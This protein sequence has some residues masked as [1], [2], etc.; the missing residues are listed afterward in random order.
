MTALQNETATPTANDKIKCLVD[1]QMVHSI[2]NHIE[3]NL[4][5]WTIQ[6][7]QEAYPDTPLFS[8]YGEMIKQ[9]ALKNAE[10][11]RKQREEK[12]RQVADAA[13]APVAGTSNNVVVGNFGGKQAE[14]ISKV[15]AMHELFDLGAVPA[16]MG[17]KGQPIAVHYYEGHTDLNSLYL[18][19]TDAA[20]VFNIDLLK[21]VILALQLNFPMLLWGKHGTGK[22][23]IVAQAS[24]RT[25]RPVMRVQ[26]TMNM[27]ESDVIGQWTV[28]NSETVFE[29]GPL[30]TA[31]LNGWVYIADEYDFAMPAVTALYQ[32]VLEGEALII[33]DA[34]AHLRKIVPHENFR[35]FATGNTNGTG[36][37]TGLYQGTT[38]Q[39]AANYSRF[40]ITE[41]VEYM[42]A[43]I[44]EAIISAKT[45]VDK[46]VS[47]NL[48]KFANQVRS[49]FTEGKISS[50]IS[51]RELISAAQIGF[52][53]GGK[54]A[55]GLQ[56]AF[57]NRLS[58]VDK[59]ACEQFMN[60][61]FKDG[62]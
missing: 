17:S 49:S 50:T 57:S 31:M 2:Q 14:L 54:W 16:A 30:P 20:Y 22:T 39:N 15:G 62:E 21:K 9:R 13:P 11:Q 53:F 19:A 36:D 25:G 5:E 45:G 24:A 8:P 41:E 26:H 4:P 40:K 48:V 29:L 51:P 56:L 44:E 61:V 23:T 28:K 52:A 1:G 38:M 47:R 32:P 27:Q 37:E 46:T 33:K 43:K 42:D 10:D 12:E 58:S 55:V 6:R 34:P 18:P 7:Y 3:K 35:F 60:R 59:S